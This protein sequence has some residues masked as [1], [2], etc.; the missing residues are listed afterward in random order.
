MSATTCPRKCPVCAG[1]SHHWL[2]SSDFVDPKDPAFE[3]AH[4]DAVG[5][6]CPECGF[7]EDAPGG[8][9]VCHDEGV[10]QR[11]PT[12]PRRPTCKAG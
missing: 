3:C 7:L 12:P 10:V 5:D 9:P 11:L 8:C 6:P 2:V 4:C 1:A